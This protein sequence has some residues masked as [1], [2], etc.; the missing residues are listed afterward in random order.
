MIG[1]WPPAERLRHWTR[2]LAL[3]LGVVALAVSTV[4]AGAP[5][6]EDGGAAA[7]ETTTPIPPSARP[8]RD[9]TAR[10]ITRPTVVPPATRTTV[11]DVTR[12]TRPQTTR[13][14]PASEVKVAAPT[15]PPAPVP[16]VTESFL[17]IGAKLLL[18]SIAMAGL[19]FLAARYAKRL[20]LAKFL[21]SVE[22]PIKI[23]GRSHL[24][25]K[26]S[27][28]LVQVG[29][30]T[31][32]VGITPTSIATLHSWDGGGGVSAGSGTDR[33]G[34]RAVTTALTAAML[35]GQLRGLETRIGSRA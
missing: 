21:P 16:S 13:P 7:T 28:M 31:L 19:L 2:P 18:G 1:A 34:T 4:T 33:G 12:A 5:D 29:A 22:G 26:T 15:P 27:L 20:P 10:P 32:L 9:I 25:P 17:G 23:I 11:S 3:T 6:P 24:G 30:T 14:A 8:T 35:P